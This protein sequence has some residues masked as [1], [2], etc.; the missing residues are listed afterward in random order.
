M[1]DLKPLWTNPPVPDVG[2]SGDS[3]ITRGGDP[4]ITVD[5]PDGLMPIWSDAFVPAMP[6]KETASPVSGL[7][8]LPNRWEPSDNP[9]EPPNLTDRTPGTIDQQ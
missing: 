8:T 3:I 2:L 5:T 7:P 4:A 6:E 1:A 9:P